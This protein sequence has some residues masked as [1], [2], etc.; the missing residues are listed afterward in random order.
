V[1]LLPVA[2]GGPGTDSYACRPGNPGDWPAPNA[3]AT[4]AADLETWIQQFAAEY[5]Q[6]NSA[7]LKTACPKCMYLGLDILGSWYVPPNKNILI[8]AAGNIDLLFTELGW[9]PDEGP[10][11]GI[12]MQSSFNTAY[13]YLTRYYGDHPILNFQN[14]TAN[15]DSAMA[16]N[17]PSG[18]LSF[19]SQANRGFGW[20]NMTSA[21]LNTLSYNNSYQGV[22]QVWWASHDFT[23]F[24][25]TNWGLK[26]PSD[27]AYDAKE[28]V[29]PIVACSSPLQ[30]YTCGGQAGN[31]GDAVT[32]I[33]AANQLWLTVH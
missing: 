1:C 16:G 25:K 24:E 11:F 12:N 19:N 31:Y 10:T 2:G 17:N 29:T 14:T 26:S 13:S 21:L 18:S 15:P 30:A 6:V 23:N 32:P 3:N 28:A 22:G 33:K 27:N 9:S 4:M 5:F 7:A 8:G 20:Y